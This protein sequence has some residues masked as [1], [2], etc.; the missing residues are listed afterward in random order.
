MLENGDGGAHEVEDQVGSGLDV[1]DVGVAEFLA[2]KLGEE[3]VE[4]PVERALLVGIV[5]VAKLLFERQ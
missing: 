3:L 2:L 5:A 4:F 1:E